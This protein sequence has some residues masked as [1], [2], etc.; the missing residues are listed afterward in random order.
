MHHIAVHCIAS[1]CTSL[2]CI[3]LRRIALHC[4]TLHYI[5][6]HCII[7]VLIRGYNKRNNICNNIN[8]IQASPAAIPG[9][10]LN[11]AAACVCVVFFRDC[12]SVCLC[13]SLCVRV[14]VCVCV[15]MCVCVCAAAR[16][17]S[18]EHGNACGHGALRPHVPPFRRGGDEE[19]GEHKVD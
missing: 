4:I 18:E 16:D 14:L 6:L 17:R 13:V 19:S 9:T 5:T 10:Q 2:H 11:P 7:R 8:T 15:C 3:T 12:F 1:H